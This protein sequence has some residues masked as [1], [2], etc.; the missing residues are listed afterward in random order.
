MYSFVQVKN[1]SFK[2]KQKTKNGRD[3]LIKAR[4]N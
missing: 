2:L 4:S 3:F 1:C